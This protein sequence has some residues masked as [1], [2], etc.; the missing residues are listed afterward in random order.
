[1]TQHNDQVDC[2]QHRYDTNDGSSHDYS[3]KVL[4]HSYKE[5][6]KRSRYH[7]QISSAYTPYPLCCMYGR[8]DALSLSSSS[9]SPPKKLKITATATS[10]T[11]NNTSVVESIVTNA[12]AT[13]ATTSATATTNIM[14]YAMDLYCI[15]MSI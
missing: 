8:N 14:I 10:A 1:M 12:T 13:T 7:G 9:P 3:N 2:L 11:A 15:L 4:H 6:G 5:K